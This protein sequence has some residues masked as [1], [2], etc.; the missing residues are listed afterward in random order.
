MIASAQRYP[1]HR[2]SHRRRVATAQRSDVPRAFREPAAVDSGKVIR[3]P[4]MQRA[5]AIAQPNTPPPPPPPFFPPPSPSLTPP[6]PKPRPKPSAVPAR[7]QPP[8]RPSGYA[9]S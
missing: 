1:S 7:P 3:H 8:K 6:P 2:A 4:A 9:P 5:A